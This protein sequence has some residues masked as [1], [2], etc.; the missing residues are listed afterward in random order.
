[1]SVTLNL[2][3]KLIW[4][5]GT[6]P[7]VGFFMSG[8]S[9][10]V[11]CLCLVLSYTETVPFPDSSKAI[12]IT[13]EMRA[14]ESSLWESTFRVSGRME[15]FVYSDKMGEL[16]SVTEALHNAEMLD[17][18]VVPREST[19]KPVEPD[20]KRLDVISIF[21]DGKSVRSVAESRASWNRDN[22]ILKWIGGPAMALLFWILA[23]VSLQI[24]VQEWNDRKAK[25][26]LEPD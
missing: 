10:I 26:K 20:Q 4:A 25:K 8:A 1:M 7:Y 14:L 17:I 19:R 11:G 15:L 6:H 18:L 21:A 13:G 5:E 3:R 9:F 23:F 12:R 22:E 16:G 2:F 24:S